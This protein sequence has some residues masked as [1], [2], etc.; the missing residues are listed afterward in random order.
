[1][2]YTTEFFGRFHLDKP[3]SKDQAAYLVQFSNIRHMSRKT[4]ALFDA[5]DLVRE[6]VGLPIGTEGE[7]FVS[8]DECIGVSDYNKNPSTQPGLWCQWCPTDDGE[9]IEWNGA[10]KFYDYTEWLEYIINHFLKV[11]GYT[12]NGD[13]EW[14]GETSDDLGKIYVKDNVVKFLSWQTLKDKMTFDEI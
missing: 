4:E 1:M 10:E 7:Y 6:A 13:V 5:N 12:L 2:G 8:D 11:W 14:R 9:G 3:L